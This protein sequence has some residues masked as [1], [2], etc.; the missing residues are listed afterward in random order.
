MRSTQEN[1]LV[2][3]EASSNLSLEEQVL[4]AE[5]IQVLK[6]VDSNLSFSSANG[7]GDLGPC[8]QTLR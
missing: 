8:F 4:R 7:D 1:S 3:S 6:C 5:T 2:M